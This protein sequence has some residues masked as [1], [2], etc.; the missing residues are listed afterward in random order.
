MGIILYITSLIARAI[1]IPIFFIYGLV[2][3]IYKRKIKEALPDIDRKFKMMA[4]SIDKFGN[5][6]G[7]E[8]LNDLLVKDKTIH[9]YGDSSET[10]SE[11]TGWNK[12]HNNLSK[13]GIMF[14]KFLDLFEKN[15]SLNSIK[16]QLKRLVE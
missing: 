8:M 1:F 4:I 7:K 11:A 12:Y 10:I 2:K 16:S 5:V 9:P 13:C 15:H 3:F 14:D 6:V